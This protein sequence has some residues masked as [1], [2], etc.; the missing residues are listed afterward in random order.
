[1]RGCTAVSQTHETFV[2]RRS[3]P[4]QSRER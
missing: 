3:A 2:L 1:V 4:T